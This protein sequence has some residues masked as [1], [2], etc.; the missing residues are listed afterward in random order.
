L[1]RR[2]QLVKNT[3]RIDEDRLEKG[4]IQ[5]FQAV[6]QNDTE[7]LVELFSGYLKGLFNIN[8]S[9]IVPRWLA[10]LPIATYLTELKRNGHEWRIRAMGAHELQLIH[11]YF[12]L[13]QFCDWN[14]QTMVNAFAREAAAEGR[15]G[16]AFP[17]EKIRQFALGKSR[18]GVLHEYQ[19]LSQP[20][21]ATKVL[22]PSRSYIFH[23]RKPQVD[24]IFPINLPERD[25]AYR[26]AVDVL[27]NFQPMPA[28]VNNYKRA[29]HPQEFFKSED[30][31]KYWASYD[32]IPKAND[33]LWDDHLGFVQDRKQKMLDTLSSLY[34]LKLAEI[35]A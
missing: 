11:Q 14:T 34:G 2:Q 28:E 35:T 10:I 12:L 15:V 19:L 17:L 22:F 1:L 18:T 9:S 27:W 24:H 3:I 16:N 20:W 7:P 13:S 30:G 29:R 5:V 4:D 25:E 32:F 6:L 8:H 23:E 26:E 31:N 21:L 33:G